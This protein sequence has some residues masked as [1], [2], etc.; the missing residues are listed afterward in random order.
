MLS[1]MD[2][3][4]SGIGILVAAALSYGVYRLVKSAI[5]TKPYRM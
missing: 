3:V 1:V 4:V 2:M 5:D